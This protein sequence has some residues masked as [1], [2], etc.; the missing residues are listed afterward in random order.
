MEVFIDDESQL[1]LHGLKQYFVKLTKDKKTKQ[2]VDLLDSLQFNQ[3]I[4][5]VSGIDRAKTLNEIL[6]NN[7]FPSVCIHSQM[8]QDNR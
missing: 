5:F 6:C 3:V 1:T 7:K 8:K 2:L 4:I